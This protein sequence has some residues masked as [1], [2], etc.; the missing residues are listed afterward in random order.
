MTSKDD[1]PAPAADLR[2]RAEQKANTDEAHVRETPSP[3]EAGRLLH[4][5]QVHQIELEMQNE[6]LRRAQNELEASRARYFDLFDLAPVGYFTLSEQGL[7]LEANLTGAGLL[8]VERRDL[9]KQPL[10]RFVLPEDQDI[11]YRHRK[12]LFETGAPQVYELRLLRADAAPFWARLE[13]TEAQDADGAPVCRAVMSDITARQQAEEKLAEL[14]RRKDQFLAML[15]HELRNPLAPILNAVQLLQLQK[16]ANSVQQKALA[17]LERQVGQL[18]H[19]VGDLL[20]VSRAITGR[21]ELCQEQVAVSSIVERAVETACSLI[22]QRRHEL[23]V[24]LPPDPIWLY[25]DAARLEQVVTNLLTNAAKYTNEGGHIWLS[26]QQEGDKVV[27]R[28]RDTGLGIAPAFLPHVFDLFTQAQR[29]SDRSQGGLGIG[30]TLAKRLVEMHGGTIAV[31]STLGRGSEFVVSLAV[32]PPQAMSVKTQP[33]PSEIAKPTGSAL[34]ILVVDDNL[35]A[36]NVL[37]MLAEEAGHWVRMA[38]TGPTALAAAFDYRPD[39]VLLD[40][41]LPELDGFEVAK[42]IRQDPHL[43]DIVL[44]AVTGY[45]QAADRQRMQEAGFDHY[46][47]KP[48]DFEKLRQILVEVTEKTARRPRNG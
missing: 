15:S 47:V 35:D 30:L 11:Y 23:T 29:S 48:A 24:S 7:I 3:E 8:G 27:L 4:E 17:I 40:I 22:D 42:R 2:R 28:V 41:G 14:D 12:Q 38:H 34:R 5:L 36:A 18:T 31:S 9:V 37:K 45:R 20:D 1:R 33:P 13:T 44:V 21:I 6:E 43:H 26:A 19:L 46:L 10:T 25:A 32:C 16:S 39:V